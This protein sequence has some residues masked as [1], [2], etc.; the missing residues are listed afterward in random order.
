MQKRSKFLQKRSI[1]FDFYKCKTNGVL[2]EKV[3]KA[4]V[5]SLDEFL[6]F[7]DEDL[8]NHE[9]PLKQSIQIKIALEEV[10]VNTAHYAYPNKDGDVKFLIGFNEKEKEFI[11]KLIDN[12]IPFNPLLKD[13]PD[14]TLSAEERDIGG[15]GIFITKKTMDK[16][17]YSYENKENILTI[18]KKI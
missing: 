9:C 6:E 15:L 3:F 10:F 16:V 13:D 14:I 18:I 5:E 2:K 12:G 8:N 17:M 7:V 1:I 11:F 4:K